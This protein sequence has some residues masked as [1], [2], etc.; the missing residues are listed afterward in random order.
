VEAD[1][2]TAVYYRRSA[3][4]Y[5]EQYVRESM[6]MEQFRALFGIK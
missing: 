6:Q 1:H 4:R 5:A 3:Q 2:D